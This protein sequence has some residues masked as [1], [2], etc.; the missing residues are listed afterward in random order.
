MT[1][2]NFGTD[3][4]IIAG[5]I[6]RPP[7]TDISEFIDLMDDIKS[8]ISR[9]N[10]ECYLLADWNIN[11]LNFDCHKLTSEFL[12]SMFSD[13]YVPLINKPTRVRERSAT[14]IENIFFTNCNNFNE[15]ITGIR[16]FSNYP[17]RLS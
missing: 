7:N 5:V 14:L 17:Y 12:E 15:S 10:E 9:E 6:Y 13:M 16:P 3:K 2:C 1:K 11:L 4:H 8:K